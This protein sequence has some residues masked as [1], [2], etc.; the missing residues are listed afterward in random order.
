MKFYI[1]CVLFF[2]SFSFEVS[3]EIITRR[4]GLET[5]HGTIQSSGELGLLVKRS[6]PSDELIRL[7]WSTIH[8]IEPKKA[9]PN[10]DAF[11]TK[12]ELLWRAKIRLLRG[13]V[14]LSQPIF[15]SQFTRLVGSDGI[16][17]RLVSEGLLR[18]LLAQGLLDKAIAPWLETVRLHEVGIQSPYTSLDSILE[19]ESLLCRHLPIMVISSVPSSVSSRN[20]IESLPVTSALTSLLLGAASPEQESNV[21]F[22]NQIL[23]A[24]SGSQLAIE[25]LQKQYDSF[26]SWQQIWSDYASARACLSTGDRNLAMIFLVKVASANP[27]IQ[28]YLTGSAMLLLANELELQT[29]V[30]EANRIRYEAKRLFPTH[31]LLI[32][33]N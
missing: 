13:D 21:V 10:I 6:G 23:K 5:I 4:D 28:P 15:E 11:L 18:T 30:Q 14:L 2:I 12:G 8:T 24:S 16:D 26:D 7:P 1:L 22:A 9:R 32:E 3:A 33:R 27:Q 17:A 19:E 29:K 20:Q 25:E 31:P